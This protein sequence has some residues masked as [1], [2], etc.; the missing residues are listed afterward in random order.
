MTEPWEVEKTQSVASATTETCEYYKGR[1]L[2]RLSPSFEIYKPRSSAGFIATN[3]SRNL[4]H[5][6]SQAAN[7]QKVY[8]VR[9]YHDIRQHNRETISQPYILSTCPI[10]HRLK[11]Y[12]LPTDRIISLTPNQRKRCL[13]TTQP[14]WMRSTRTLPPS[15]ARPLCLL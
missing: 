7:G 8:T 5:T 2:H 6:K 12:L 15:G 3:Q 11:L 4:I 10:L 14:P 13:H 9:T 1:A